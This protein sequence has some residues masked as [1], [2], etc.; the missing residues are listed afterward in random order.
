MEKLR[1]RLCQI[2][3]SGCKH[4]WYN[5][6]RSTSKGCQV[7]SSGNCKVTP[8]NFPP[9]RRANTETIPGVTDQFCCL[10]YSYQGVGQH[11]YSVLIQQLKGR[12]LLAPL[13]ANT[14]YSRRYSVATRLKYNWK[15]CI[16]GRTCLVPTRAARVVLQ[17][18][19]PC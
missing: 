19:P 10:L 18:A 15:K 7:N 4:A 14:R 9:R 6:N 12:Y 16:I 2:E 3:K 5:H 11:I 13:Y 8:I 1:N 17:R